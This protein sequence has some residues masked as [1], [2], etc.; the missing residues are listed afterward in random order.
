[1]K[2]IKPVSVILMALYL[3]ACSQNESTRLT[4]I[5][6]L[7]PDLA[8]ELTDENNKA[9][10]AKDYLGYTV[11]V[12]FGFTNCPGVCPTTM[13][14][15]V[16]ILDKIGEPA[17]TVKV[18]FISVD[19]KRDSA[20]KLKKYT[21]TFGPAFIGLRGDDEVIKDMTKRY[22]VTFGYGDSDKEGNYEVSHSGAVFVFDKT[23]EARLLVTQSSAEEDILYDLKNLIDSSN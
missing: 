20:E 10:S 18:L 19:P 15:L 17:S 3:S 23:G 9:V 2:I 16:E 5:K 13:H 14:Q 4:N 6:G 7:I 1:M 8:F 11:A 22:R 21:Q 12:F